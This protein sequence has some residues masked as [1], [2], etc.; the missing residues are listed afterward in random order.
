MEPS[1]LLAL[2]T[3]LFGGTHCIGMCG[4]IVASYSLEGAIPGRPGANLLKKILPH[5]L[6]NL[7]RVATY[8]FTGAV[9]GLAGS[10]INSISLMQNVMAI[11]AGV[12]MIIM[13]LS[14]TGLF[15][16][17]GWLEQRGSL[18][19][20]T[21]RELLLQRSVW[22]Y[23]I[24]GSLFGFLPCGLSYSVFTAAAG[25]GSLVS[26]MMLSLLFGL[27]TVPWLLLFG[28][29]SSH[30]STAFRGR[31]YKAAGFIVIVMGVLFLL[32]G[33]RHYA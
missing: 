25:S 33:I 17:M 2:T 26:G 3:G 15:G 32:K 27:G 14:I 24:L 30:I 1:F 11:L 22:K 9:M 8:A 31:V 6:Y 12:I 28:I 29:A 10:F 4:P 16:N 20:K 5:L 13:G 19:R 21:G 18:I 23:F 7:G